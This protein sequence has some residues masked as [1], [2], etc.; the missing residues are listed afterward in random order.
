MY[1]ASFGSE[2]LFCGKIAVIRVGFTMLFT[3][4]KPDGDDVDD[5]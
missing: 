2:L 4:D 3:A 5:G 1:L